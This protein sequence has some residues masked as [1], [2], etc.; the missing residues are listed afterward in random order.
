MSLNFDEDSLIIENYKELGVG[1]YS[2]DYME[3]EIIPKTIL[4]PNNGKFT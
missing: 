1:S 2:M 3:G 4:S